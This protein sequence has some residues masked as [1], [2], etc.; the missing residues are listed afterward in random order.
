M[1]LTLI[2]QIVKLVEKRIKEKEVELRPSK[3]QKNKSLSKTLRNYK[4]ALEIDNLIS[5]M[6]ALQDLPFNFVEGIGFRRLLQF[7]VPNYQLRRRHFFTSFIYDE[8]YP[9]LSIIL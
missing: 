4:D 1:K 3:R 6:I 2:R 8:L 7:I 9:W 5:Q